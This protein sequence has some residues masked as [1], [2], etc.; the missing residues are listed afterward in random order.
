MADFDKKLVNG[1]VL[2]DVAKGI[3]ER[4]EDKDAAL[5]TALSA[6]SSIVSTLMMLSAPLIKASSSAVNPSPALLHD[7]MHN[8]SSVVCKFLIVIVLTM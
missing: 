4:A 8:M 7:I 2:M 3:L 5:K 6:A 1:A